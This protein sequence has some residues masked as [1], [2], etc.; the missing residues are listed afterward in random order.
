M[1]KKFQGEM[2]NNN[3]TITTHISRD[4]IA[5]HTNSDICVVDRSRK[6]AKSKKSKIIVVLVSRPRSAADA[7]SAAA[8]CA[9]CSASLRRPQHRCCCCCR[10]RRRRRCQ[11]RHSGI[12][13]Y[14]K[15]QVTRTTQTSIPTIVSFSTS[16]LRRHRRCRCC[17]RLRRLRLVHW[18]LLSRN[19]RTSNS[20]TNCV[21]SQRQQSI[22]IPIEPASSSSSSLFERIARS[23]LLTT[24]GVVSV[25]LPRVRVCAYL[26]IESNT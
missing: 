9:S 3:T 8:S 6:K 26:D 16:S 20:Q 24:P 17:W 5:T 7:G 22:W 12:E 13:E 14:V 4:E 19:K 15:H 1:R 10:R 11:L 25:P 2:D 18:P 23:L 21:I